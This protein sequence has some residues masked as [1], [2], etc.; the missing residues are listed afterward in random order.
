MAD[1]TS[2]R[3]W[4]LVEKDFMGTISI[5]HTIKSM[6]KA[7]TDRYELWGESSKEQRHLALAVSRV[8]L[9]KRR[10]IG[11][12]STNESIPNK[13]GK[14][15]Y[16]RNFNPPQASLERLSKYNPKWPLEKI[17]GFFTDED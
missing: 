12:E 11:K 3:A 6:K 17:A 13:P 7:E 2:E 14:V 16:S 1:M 5:L 15:F 8:G 9:I 4:S 10:V